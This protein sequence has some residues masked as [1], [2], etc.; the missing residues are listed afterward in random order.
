M[1]KIC[2]EGSVKNFDDIPDD[3]KKIFVTAHDIEPEWHLKIQSI[4]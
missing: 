4:F 3:I 1:E 2:E